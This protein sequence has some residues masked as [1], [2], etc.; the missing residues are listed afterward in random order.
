MRLRKKAPCAPGPASLLHTTASPALPLFLAPAPRSVCAAPP[1]LS[2]RPTTHR[3]RSRP[4]RLL[5]ASTVPPRYSTARL[6]YP[7]QA[8]APGP[9]PPRPSRHPTV[10]G[11]VLLHRLGLSMT[12]SACSWPG[13]CPPLACSRPVD[14]PAVSSAGPI[15]ALHAAASSLIGPRARRAGPAPSSIRTVARPP[16]LQASSS[17]TPD[18]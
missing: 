8:D 16:S 6:L 12:R 15:D 2:G 17:S 5:S 4:Q 7:G 18:S 9:P 14:A 10:V 3:H 1:P 11:E 13:W